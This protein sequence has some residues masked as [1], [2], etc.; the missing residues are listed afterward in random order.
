MRL[1]RTAKRTRSLKFTNFVLRIMWVDHFEKVFGTMKGFGSD[2]V[3]P[4]AEIGDA[5]YAVQEQGAQAR[6]RRCEARRKEGE[7]RLREPELPQGDGRRALDLED[8]EDSRIGNYERERREREAGN[9][10]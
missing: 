7:A 3:F 5:L 10:E 9:F 8:S 1:L 4:R 2:V 6:E